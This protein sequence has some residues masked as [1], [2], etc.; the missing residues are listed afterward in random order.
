[1]TSS[2]RSTLTAILSGKLPRIVGI[3]AVAASLPHAE[4]QTTA[5]WSTAGNGNWTDT[6]RWS[7]GAT[8]NS[9]NDVFLNAA[10]ANGNQT[11]YLAGNQNANSI[12]FQNTG[13]TN[14]QGGTS[15]TAANNTLTIGSGGILVSA[16]AGNVTIGQ[17]GTA[18]VV[19]IAG[20]G[21][22][23][24]N[25]SNTLTIFGNSTY[26]GGTVINSGRVYV[27]SGSVFSGG[28]LVSGVLGNGT[29]T[30]AEGTALGGSSFAV[31]ATRWT[32]NGNM[33][34]GYSGA[35]GRIGVAGPIDLNGTTP[36]NSAAGTIR[37]ISLFNSFTAASVTGSTSG[38]FN[39]DLAPSNTAATSI[40]NGTLRIVPDP[41]V[42]TNLVGV[43]IG[44]TTFPNASGLTI[45]P[46][47]I[48]A[49]PVGTP[50]TAG[51]TVDPR[52]TVES[53]G[54]F[55][56]GATGNGTSGAGR[57][58]YIF[59]LAGAGVVTNLSNNT[60]SSNSPITIDGNA[61]TDFSGT[62]ADGA[63]YSSTFT[64]ISNIS[65]TISLTRGGTGTQILSGANSYT[66]ST[67][68]T[69]GVLQLG[70]GGTTGALSTSSNISVS[71]G[72]TFAINRS[73]AVAQGT[74][75]S[76]NPISG[77]GGFSQLGSG[78][79]TLNVANTYT[80]TSTINGGR[81]LLVGSGTLGA[82]TSALSMGGG[83]LDLGGGS[84]NAGAVTI[85]APASSG[86]TIGNGT[87]TGSSFAVS[88]AS[89]T[90]AISATLNGTGG[91]TK[92]GAGTLTLN[93]SN[94]YSGTTAIN[95][96]LVVASAS[97]TVLGSGSL[98]LGGGNLTVAN[99]SD[100]ALN[101]NTTISS[102]TVL[103]SERLTSGAG[104]TQ[105]LGTLSIGAN[106][107]S[108]ARGSNVA[109]G[110]AGVTFGGT[111]LTGAA[112]FDTATGTNLTL[113]AIGGA[114]GITKQ[115]AG[116]LTLN[117]ASTRSTTAATTTLSG[118]TVRI[119]ALGAL[120]TNA[121]AALNLNG[122][123][124]SI[125][126]DTG[127]TVTGTATTVGGNAAIESDRATLG[128]GVSSTLG[129]LSIGANTLS[130]TKGSNVTSGT[131]SITFGATTFTG[132][133]TFSVASGSALTLGAVT[134]GGFSPTF[135]GG[136]NISQSAVWTGSGTNLVFD[137][138]FSGTASLNQANTFTG[139]TTLA[140]GSLVIGTGTT[141]TSGSIVSGPLGN[142]TVFLNGG[143]LLDNG[144]ARTL[145]NNIVIG[146]NLTIAST[147]S[148]SITWDGRSV[149]SPSVITL[150]STNATLTI[151]SQLTINNPIVN[152]T[153]SGLVKSGS[154]TLILTP[155]SSAYVNAGT[156]NG[157]ATVSLSNTSGIQVGQSVGG[158]GIPSST[159]GV[160]VV[161][162]NPG[163]SI[164]LS[165][166]A[167]STTTTNLTFQGN[168]Y[169]GGTVLNA[170]TV[171]VSNNN[172][173]IDASGNLK[174]GL[175]GTGNLTVNSGVIITST[176][177]NNPT[178][179]APS[180]KV[181]GDFTVNLASGASGVRTTWLGDWDVSAAPTINISG[182]NATYSTVIGASGGS[183]TFALSSINTGSARSISINGSFTADGTPSTTVAG[184]RILTN[185]TANFLNN[186]NLTVG[187]KVLLSF[188]S[189]TALF[190]TGSNAPA[191]TVQNGGMMS[192]SSS[193][194]S[195]GQEVYSLQ[196]SGTVTN[197]STA[198]ADAVLTV[199]NGNSA[200]FSGVIT[201]GVNLNATTGISA[202][203]RVALTKTG[204]GIQILSGANSY[205][206][207][208]I[209]NG[210]TLQIGNG[211]TTGSLAVA[212]AITNNA[213]LAFNR[214]D[215][216]DQGTHF[217]S[218]ITGS[219]R[220][221][222][223]GS[224][225]LNLDGS[226]TFSG[227]TVVETGTVQFTTAG[228]NATAAQSLGTN[229]SVDLG[230]AGVSSGLLDYTG[231]G[232]TTLAKNINALGNGNDTIRNSSSGL[233]TLTGTLTKNGTILTIKGGTGGISVNGT[234][235]GSASA[236]DLVVD[237]GTV[238][239]NAANTYN[240]PTSIKN[241]ATLNANAVNSLGT[242]TLVTV[243]S[244]STLAVNVSGAVS[245]TAPVVLA[246]GSVSRGSGVTETFGA[247]ALTASSSIN[248][249]TGTAG[250]LNFGSY[251]GNGY[252]LSVLNF[253]I[254]NTLT[255]KTNLS[256][257]IRN[258]DLFAFSG[259]FSYSW[260]N[261]SSTFTITAVPEPT[262]VAAAVAFLGLA[263]VR[264]IRR[265]RR[266][267]SNEVI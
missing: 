59:S 244:G 14:L 165:Q 83:G 61:T 140:S 250:T 103:T 248:F 104:V 226:N 194:L 12:T 88:N 215:T 74:D 242:T 55:N 10:G 120:S 201:D 15:T 151:N 196:G 231:S 129:T 136:G 107:L 20:S 267:G 251:V 222:Q 187:N 247:L 163:V 162:I 206:G 134:G 71:S 183:S 41:S 117:N 259:G 236:S 113:G 156:T 174:S 78:T 143:S 133:P 75:F 130:I 11:V 170:G 220:V 40:A 34:V 2:F 125:G 239:L 126:T 197:L 252:K 4:A 221:V 76:S 21:G 8:P 63:N 131:G 175:F 200:N 161:S 91:L 219:G 255:F 64:G 49:I 178:I 46:R 209:I 202:L 92:T 43:Q 94:S 32:I 172:P 51:G 5:N 57:T 142:G 180:T 225:I 86:D 28:S 18:R 214:T 160:Y 87:L 96:G 84:K 190:G 37:T 266:T 153:G 7:T 150:N 182:A 108:I 186:S 121:S 167:T 77:A 81:V 56:T 25:G 232:A 195:V 224:G 115:G 157:T 97:S 159:T 265:R 238:N 145:A 22:L 210:G 149:T 176:G 47:V 185:T 193:T 260:N 147:G 105:T 256:D 31:G 50:F 72:A 263:S 212:S 199:S 229:A 67:S 218:V 135:T 16:G 101:R 42:T 52:L 155:T 154:G 234:I 70:N 102:S 230:V 100:L 181:N 35:T 198:A 235:A 66:G 243:E 249:G 13:I 99:D 177:G 26:T 95:G 227:R 261:S 53:G 173:G 164:T 85:S 264:M 158:T 217:A 65:G 254:G 1:M 241:G 62:I 208:T 184:L 73:N 188:G 171:Q 257:S 139:N 118:G 168:T 106:T 60:I 110:T 189:T 109:S 237:G 90:V 30:L 3:A 82:S 132:S 128:A 93:G 9:G 68:I 233:L 191:L 228:S 23:T 29:V 245:D 127:G 211:G 79:T 144:T 123:T 148:A 54:Y 17:S 69:G 258:T 48:T 138:G 98:T 203:G 44:T 116:T 205:N 119:G 19:S 89:G 223:R 152:G 192:L 36:T 33:S 38:S 112:V 204:S 6:A 122:G 27:G 146:G 207:S 141:V 137:S 240:G 169:T 213:T 111:T 124:L 80:G 45:G 114:F 179:A 246:G 216:V 39:L 58:I 166:N 24:M 262:A 253:D